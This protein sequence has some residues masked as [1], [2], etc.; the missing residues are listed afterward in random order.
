MRLHFH[1]LLARSG[2]IEAVLGAVLRVLVRRLLQLRSDAALC[3]ADGQHEN[4]RRGLGRRLEHDDRRRLRGVL[5]P[6]ET[7][8]GGKLFGRSPAVA[9]PLERGFLGESR[10]PRVGHR[11]VR[12][13]RQSH[14][15]TGRRPQ[16][17][18][19]VLRVVLHLSLVDRLPR[20]L[21]GDRRRQVR[22]PQ[23]RRLV[24]RQV[25]PPHRTIH[26]RPALPLPRL[27]DLHVAL[28][29]HPRRHLSPRQRRAHAQG[30]RGQLLPAAATPTLFTLLRRA[31]QEPRPTVTTVT[32]VLRRRVTSFA[33]VEKRGS[34]LCPSFVRSFCGGR[35]VSIPHLLHHRAVVCC[36]SRP[37]LCLL[38]PCC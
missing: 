29:G 28:R 33:L 10:H 23:G 37:L 38:V 9:L 32:T 14:A 36:C 22:R 13:A 18:V 34:D 11:F 12:L 19:V 25:L 5:R 4:P 27:Q 2:S 1:G 35:T 24:L 17:S 30:F 16:S 8:R 7:P 21:R 31:G 3:V 26:H 15:L 6:E 20:P